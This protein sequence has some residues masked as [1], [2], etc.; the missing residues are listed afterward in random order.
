MEIRR[1]EIEITRVE[2]TPNPEPER[3]P[4]DA[5]DGPLDDDDDARFLDRADARRRAV[6]QR[7][8]RS[9]DDERSD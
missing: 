7:R 9:F 3:E 8:G 2:V 5:H 4:Y 1:T 6:E